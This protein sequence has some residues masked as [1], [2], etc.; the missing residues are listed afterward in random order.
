METQSTI[1]PYVIGLDLGGTNSVFGI[2][3]ARGDI[4]ATTAIKTGGFTSAE[5]YVAASVEA[6]QPII[7]QV[8]GIDTI[9]AMGIGAPNGNYYNGTIEFAPNL[10]WAHDG[11]VPLAKMFSDK[12]NGIPVALTNDANA[13]A[14]GEMVYGVARGMKNF[15][16][17][18]LGTGVGSGIVVNGQLLYGHD[19]F[20][21]ELGHVIMRRENGRSCGCG[22]TGC[23]EAYCSATGVAR[24]AREILS[25]TERPS[26][27]RDINPAD[28]T[29]LDVSIA[30]EKG[31]EL[32]N[33]IY[34][35]TGN[36]LGE[37]CADFAAFSSPEAFIFFGG[38]T[39]AGELI[40][41]PIRESYD[42][43]VLKIFKG[44]AKF[45]VSGL[46]GSSAAVLGASAVGWEV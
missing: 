26:L 12:L 30:A 7:E 37:A 45:L 24:T 21:G 34:E 39:K 16:V 19:G 44:K 36:M 4:K 20:A 38:M 5:D 40:M 6:L 3:D 41:K 14:I 42:K 1:K 35:F 10:P 27:L 18:T 31:D 17:I 29:S 2:V 11:I 8:G 13:A 46:D 23:L 33:E 43:H 15:I 9:K 25:T 32:A 22:R 28:I